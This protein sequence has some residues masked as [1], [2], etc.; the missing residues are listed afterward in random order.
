MTMFKVNVNMN[1]A[2]APGGTFEPLPV[3]EY[4]CEILAADVKPTSTPGRNLIQIQLRV[5]EPADFRNRRIFDRR[6]IPLDTEGPES[7]V[8]QRLRELFDAVPGCFDFETGA[9]DTDMMVNQRVMVKT[10]NE[11][12]NRPDHA[13]EVQTRVAKIYVPQDA[14]T[15]TS[16]PAEAPA[17]A[18]APVAAPVAAAPVAKPAPAKAAPK[19][20]PAKAPVKAA[21][22]A[23][24]AP[25]QR[26]PFRRPAGMPQPQ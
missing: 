19:P 17:E 9:G 8:A 2:Q 24:T 11:A 1:E 16:A 23:A 15:N 22:V 4:L 18:P 21:P 7:F 12:D 26:S 10:R 13:G 20:A 5:E 14:S 25:V 6:N 3:G